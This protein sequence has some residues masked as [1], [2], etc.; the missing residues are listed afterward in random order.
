MDRAFEVISP[1]FDER[2]I[3]HIPEEKNAKRVQNILQIFS[4]KLRIG[5]S[6]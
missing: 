1:Y 6:G 5:S 3:F 2:N 4:S